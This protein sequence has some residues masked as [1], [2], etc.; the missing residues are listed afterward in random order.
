MSYGREKTVVVMA[1]WQGGIV[2]F[3]LHFFLQPYYYYNV[4]GNNNI[5]DTITNR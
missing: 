2:S 1:S 4:R 3:R 5:N